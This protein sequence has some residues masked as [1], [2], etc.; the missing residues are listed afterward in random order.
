MVSLLFVF[1][2]G[3]FNPLVANSLEKVVTLH[4]SAFCFLFAHRS[5]RKRSGFSAGWESCLKR[6]PLAF[7]SYGYSNFSV[8]KL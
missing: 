8:L 3:G 1:G 4:H 2:G 5:R 6:A 7:V